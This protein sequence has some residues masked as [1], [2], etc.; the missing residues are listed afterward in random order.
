MGA[1]WLPGQGMVS[2][3]GSRIGRAV[4]EYD[5]RLF[6]ARN[7]ETGDYCIFIKMGPGNPPYPLYG[8]REEP[9]VEEALRV[10]QDRDTKRR[11]DEI[12]REMHKQRELAHAEQ[13]YRASEAAGIYAEGLE[14]YLHDQG[15][16]RY[17]RSLRPL[18]Q[19]AVRRP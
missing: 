15:Q 5:D 13:D 11:G 18:K 12:L 6:Y 17:F 7:D 19:T 8:W 2:L 1:L 3:E 14:S 10:V 16:T 4:S 9:S